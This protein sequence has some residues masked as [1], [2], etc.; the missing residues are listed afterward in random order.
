MTGDAV[1]ARGG[2]GANAVNG[3][4]LKN[5]FSFI[6]LLNNCTAASSLRDT[7]RTGVPPMIESFR[8][9]SRIHVPPGAA[10]NTPR[11]RQARVAPTTVASSG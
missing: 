10:L 4:G 5:A 2:V 6:P 11:D 3:S 1:A 9:S 8:A 7:T